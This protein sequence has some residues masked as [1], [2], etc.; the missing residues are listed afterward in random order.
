MEAWGKRTT[1]ETNGSNDGDNP[2]RGEQAETELNGVNARTFPFP[3]FSEFE[4]S[5]ALLSVMLMER[6]LMEHHPTGF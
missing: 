3:P 2:E 5:T 4:K 6:M 1:P